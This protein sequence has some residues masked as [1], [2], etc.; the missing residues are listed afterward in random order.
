MSVNT[1]L[2][3]VSDHVLMV[4][5][6]ISS[7]AMLAYAGDFAYGRRTRTAAPA[8]QPV[9]ELAGVGARGAAPDVAD[10]DAEAASAAGETPAAPPVQGGGGDADGVSPGGLEEGRARPGAP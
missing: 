3:A 2:A 6:V 9:S 1:G 5:V 7:L 4:A 8:V 10:G